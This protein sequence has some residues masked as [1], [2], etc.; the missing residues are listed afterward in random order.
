M[1]DGVVWIPQNS[2]GCK[3]SSLGV[4]PGEAVTVAAEV[5]K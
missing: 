3:I 2:V 4:R 5:R 1:P